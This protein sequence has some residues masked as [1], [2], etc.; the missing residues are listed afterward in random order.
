MSLL[1][2]ALTLL[3]LGA[4]GSGLARRVFPGERGVVH[5]AGAL[6]LGAAA[7][8]LLLVAASVVGQRSDA[9]ALAGA[10]LGVA[11][12]GRRSSLRAEPA[13]PARA[14]PP[15]ALIAGAL[16]VSVVGGVVAV[17]LPF[18]GDGGKF[19]GA[20]GQELAHEPASRAG[21]LHDPGRLAFHRE[22][23]LL[24]P[25]LL[26]PA[27]SLS[28]AGAS[29]GPKLV[30]HGL[31]AALLVLAM[32][33]LGRR[34]RGGRTLGVLLLCVPAFTSE[35]L[36][37]SAVAGGYVDGVAAL[38]LLLLVEAVE[39]A[40]GASPGRTASAALVLATLAGGAL[41]ST[42]LEGGVALALVLGAWVVAGPVRA[43][44]GA[45]AVGAVLLALPT[46]WL[47]GSVVPDP[48]SFVLSQAGEL[49]AR[50]PIILAG[51][52]GLLLDVSSL[53]LLPVALLLWPWL[54]R[55]SAPGGSAGDP[56]ARTP[57]FARLLVLGMLAFL[58]LAYALTVMN[59]E[60]HLFTSSHRL[61]FQWLPAFALLAAGPEREHDHGR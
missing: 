26:A 32:A 12:V 39:C 6:A 16:L 34:G 18:R 54:D 37:E 51:L 31:T 3:L 46:I 44:A 30:L 5:G 49:G 19:W 60:R 29:A 17:G 9:L 27:F 11:W 8:G 61:L 56:P 38:F 23:P 20:R 41:L 4:A 13:A 48:P 52:G 2:G 22:Y 24:V 58:V 47:R 42:K 43:G 40:R 45:V 50:L 7:V 53:G 21:A 59:V 35:D 55:R 14:G 36:R 57:A 28:P 1:A 33:R 25:A 10:A 15:R